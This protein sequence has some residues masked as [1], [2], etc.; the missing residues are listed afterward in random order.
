[1]ELTSNSTRVVFASP[2]SGEAPSVTQE[3]N[4]TFGPDNWAVDPYRGRLIYTPYIDPAHKDEQRSLARQKLQQ[5]ADKL[6]GQ[7][8]T[9]GET[10]FLLFS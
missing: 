2:D 7:V 1:M 8:K 10:V 3:M 4:A 6:G 9:D 5:I